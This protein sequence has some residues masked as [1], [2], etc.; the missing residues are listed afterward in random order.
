MK[1]EPQVTYEN[2]SKALDISRDRYKHIVRYIM[3]IMKDYQGDVVDIVKEIPLN[4]K[5]K[6]KYFAMYMMG[7][8][9]SPVFSKMKDMQKATFIKSIMEVLKIGQEEAES[10]TNYMVNED[11]ENMKKNYVPTNIDM[12]K[13]IIDSDFT[14][15]EKNYLLFMLGLI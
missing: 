1:I 15:T 3:N 7:S 6:E 10:I 9:S 13:K 2:I 14:E 5:G 11:L 12:I 4:L 8:S